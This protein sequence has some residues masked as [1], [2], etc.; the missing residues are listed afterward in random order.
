M[1]QVKTNMHYVNSIKFGFSLSVIA[2]SITA[3]PSV[4]WAQQQVSIQV[5]GTVKPHCGFQDGGDATSQSDNELLFSVNPDEENWSKQSRKIALSLS[6]NAPFTLAVRSSQGGLKNTDH[7]G[8]GI[9][10]HFSNEIAYELA[11]NMTTEDAAVLLVLACQSHELAGTDSHC[12]ASSGTNAAIGR[13]AGVGEVAVT[14][15]GSSGFP[16][17]GRYQ[18]TIVLALAFQ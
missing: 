7:T 17:R 1:Q 4:G 15:S 16:I 13:G 18:D 10:G 3:L 12:G 2:F 11:L 9:G 8:K 14:L 5:E 6:C